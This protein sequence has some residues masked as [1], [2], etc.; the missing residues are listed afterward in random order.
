MTL[1]KTNTGTKVQTDLI[2]DSIKVV[3]LSLE[4]F[5]ILKVIAWGS[6]ISEEQAFANV[7]EAGLESLK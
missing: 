2:E 1:G 3:T 4:D 7:I 5:D 6:K